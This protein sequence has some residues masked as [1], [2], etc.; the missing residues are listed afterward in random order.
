MEVKDLP[1]RPCALHGGRKCPLG[2]FKCMKDI[3][4]NRVFDNAK[5]MLAE[6][7]SLPPAPG[8]SRKKPRPDN[9]AGC[10]AYSLPEDIKTPAVKRGF[11]CLK[12]P[13]AMPG[14][15]LFNKRLYMYT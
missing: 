13:P 8:K 11:C 5:E 4:P 7:G 2:H 14:D 6:H 10:R 1:C 9:L 15:I 3:L 12:N